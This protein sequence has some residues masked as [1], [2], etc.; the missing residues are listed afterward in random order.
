MVAQG[1]FYRLQRES[2][3]QSVC[4][5]AKTSENETKGNTVVKQEVSSPIKSVR[6]DGNPTFH[7]IS[8]R[9]DVSTKEKKAAFWSTH[10]LSAIK[11][12][13][14]TQ[15]KQLEKEKFHRAEDDVNEFSILERFMHKHTFQRRHLRSEAVRII[16]NRQSMKGQL[17]EFWL[18][19]CY[20]P[21]T[22][23]ILKSAHIRAVTNQQTHLAAAPFIQ[24]IVR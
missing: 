15:V 11:R 4:E 24:M 20:I 7:T 9:R 21:A 17:D 12:K 14:R 5:L 19:H 16:L 2:S 1:I 22:D 6:F 8:N 3:S 23:P 13:V 10:E 18:T